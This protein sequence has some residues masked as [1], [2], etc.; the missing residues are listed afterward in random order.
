M[1]MI[2]PTDHMESRRKEDQG[3]DGSVLNC[4][5]STAEFMGFLYIWVGDISTVNISPHSVTRFF[6]LL[7]AAR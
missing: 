7:T 5:F 1:P 3:V 2:Q 6:L 4:C